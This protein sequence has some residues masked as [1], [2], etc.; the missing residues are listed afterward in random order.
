[1][2]KWKLRFDFPNGLRHPSTCYF[3]VVNGTVQFFCSWMIFTGL[4]LSI[5]PI[6]SMKM[7]DSEEMWR[8]KLQ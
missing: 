2:V 4:A 1:M 5:N 3:I 7:T 8:S 6:K